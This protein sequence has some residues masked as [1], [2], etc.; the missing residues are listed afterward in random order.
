MFPSP[1][2]ENASTPTP[3]PPFPGSFQDAGVIRAAY[4]LNFPLLVLPAPGPAPAA[5]WSA[6]SVSSPAVVLETVKQARGGAVGGGAPAGSA[7]APPT[8]HLPP[9]AETSPQGRTLVLRLY[10]AHGSHVDCWLHTSL[11][12]QEAVL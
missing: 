5:S 6:F 2:G 10:E 12:V 1:P 3:P 7:Q 4:S 11:P 8:T 9:Q